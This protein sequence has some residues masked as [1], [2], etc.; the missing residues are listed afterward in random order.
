MTPLILASSSRYRRDLLARLRL[1]F[2]CRAPEIDERP[3]AGESP[4]ALARRLAETKAGVIAAD[5]DHGLVI[6]SDQVAVNDG[7]LLGKPG[8]RAAAIQ[9]LVAAS[10]RAVVFQT[11]VCICDA[12]SGAR[13][14]AVVPCTV[15]FR[16]LGIAEIT[17]YLDTEEPYDCAGSFKAEGLG[18]VLFERIEGDDPT[19]LTG[20]PLIAL[21]RLLREAGRD[22]LAELQ[23]DS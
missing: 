10:G 14:S 16:T 8:H 13:C 1:P 22:V 19:A 21:T 18:I 17:T 20:L 4:V 15:H 2:E 12:E 3:Q 23:A 6:G 9:Q 5:L 7:R 11:A